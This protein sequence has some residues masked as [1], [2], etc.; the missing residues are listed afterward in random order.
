MMSWAPHST[1]PEKKQ[2]IEIR[3]AFFS[4]FDL[5]PANMTIPAQ[6]KSSTTPLRPPGAT[7]ATICNE[8]TDLA[9]FFLLTISNKVSA[10]SLNN[11]AACLFRRQ[12]PRIC[13]NL[14]TRRKIIQVIDSTFSTA[15]FFIPRLKYRESTQSTKQP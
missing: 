6:P 13:F 14:N 5:K 1:K 2:D 7:R 15:Q 9:Q 11:F 8:A 12:P 3:P 4:M 10:S